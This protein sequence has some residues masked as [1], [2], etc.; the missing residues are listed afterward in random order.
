MTGKALRTDHFG[1]I[2]SKT[3]ILSVLTLL[4]GEKKQKYREKGLR[5]RQ[6]DNRALIVRATI[7]F[8]QLVTLLFSCCFKQTLDCYYHCI[9]SVP[10]Q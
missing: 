10:V 9:L 1:P 5:L 3:I 8:S 4:S 7:F 2:D 6:T